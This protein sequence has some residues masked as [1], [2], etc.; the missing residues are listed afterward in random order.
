MAPRTVHYV[1]AH[2]VLRDIALDPNVDLLEEATEVDL[3][4]KLADIWADLN[5]R[6]P[7]ESKIPGD[8]L[9]A[10]VVQRPD[11]AAVLVTMPEPQ[12]PAEAYATMVVSGPDE[13]QTLYYT[14]EYG[15]DTATGE[16]AAF[17]CGWGQDP[18]GAGTTHYNY[19]SRD[20]TSIDTFVDEVGKHI[21]ES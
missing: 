19:G 8:G 15:H 17:L 6:V 18:H 1:F 2:R 20:N 5:E 12:Q 16:P 14:W 13:T 9:A 7:E 4:P 21:T 3:G 11:Y 10:Y